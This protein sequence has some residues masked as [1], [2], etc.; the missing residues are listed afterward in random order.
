MGTSQS[1]P[2]LVAAAQATAKPSIDRV[3]EALKLMDGQSG[4]DAQIEDLRA[5]TAALE[6]AAIDIY[7]VFEARSQ[8]HFR[9]GPFSRKL[10]T[11]LL[12]SGEPDLAER[13]HQYYL[14]IN[15]LKHGKGESYRELRNVPNPLFKVK[16]GDDRIA[17]E[18]QA[19]AGL[20]D[21]TAPEFFDGLTAA[22]LEAYNF[23]E[24]K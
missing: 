21:V 23:L 19:S 14:A 6:L 11:L 17:G 15:V 18:A 13:V 2:E 24:N 9:R 7:S 16:P 20:I 3:S 10:A 12:D 4:S 5:V 22:I 1:I 8:H